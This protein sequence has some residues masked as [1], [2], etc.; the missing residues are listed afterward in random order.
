MIQKTIGRQKKMANLSL[1]NPGQSGLMGTVSCLCTT[2]ETELVL[3]RLLE[4]LLRVFLS[5]PPMSPSPLAAPMAHI[6]HSLLPIPIN[7]RLRPTWFQEAPAPEPS[8]CLAFLPRGLHKNSNL[9]LRALATI[10]TGSSAF[11]GAGSSRSTPVSS[12]KSSPTGS[13]TGS[14]GNLGSIKGKRKESADDTRSDSRRALDRALSKLT[15]RLS[16]SSSRSPSPSSPVSKDAAGP[17]PASAPSGVPRVMQRAVDLLD[18]SLAHY[19][20]GNIDPD[21]AA[22]LNICNEEDVKLDNA[23]GPLVL[24]MVKVC[25]ASPACRQA[26]KAHVLPPDLCVPLVIMQETKN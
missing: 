5:L 20:P 25:K 15:P 26:F 13:P 16:L 8:Q 24:L 22:V 17:F 14:S 7:D 19:L 9:P 23:M 6:L 10:A 18:A 2:L 12:T 11:S 3:R 4:P 21:D 1:A